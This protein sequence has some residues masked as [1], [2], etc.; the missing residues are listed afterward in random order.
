MCLLLIRSAVSLVGTRESLADVE[1]FRPISKRSIIHRKQVCRQHPTLVRHCIRGRGEDCG[2]AKICCGVPG[3]TQ[4]GEEEDEWA[5]T[6][7]IGD[8]KGRVLALV[9]KINDDVSAIQKQN[10]EL[11]NVRR[12]LEKD[13]RK[14]RATSM[15]VVNV[16]PTAVK[17]RDKK[18]SF[19]RS[20]ARQ[21]CSVQRPACWHKHSLMFSGLYFWPWQ[22]HKI[23]MQP[24]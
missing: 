17:F 9:S 13:K 18:R 24:W 12:G 21:C 19:C 23:C 16:L 14:V 6:V 4:E 20:F 1:D 11:E 5:D 3:D 10:D 2:G 15:R 7:D 22:Y 8:N